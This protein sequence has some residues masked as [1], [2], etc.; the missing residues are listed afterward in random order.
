MEIKCRAE[1]KG[2][3][4]Q[5]L[6]HLGIHPHTV[7]KPRHY[8]GCQEVHV[9]RSLIWLS[10]E[11]PCHSLINTEMNACSQPLVHIWSCEY[12][13]LLLRRTE[14]PI[15]WSS[16]FLSFMCSVN[17]ILVIWSFWASIHLSVSAY[18]VCSFVIGIPLSEWYFLVL[19]ICL[20]IS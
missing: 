10:P 9:E 20:R 18:H 13:I 5:R 14:A 12:F 15:L 4:M 16:F 7:T 11:R 8:C 6:S 1:T 3:A 2:K 17:C 19:S